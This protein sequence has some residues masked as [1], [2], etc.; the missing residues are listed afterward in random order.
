[1]KA[2]PYFILFLL[3]LPCIAAAQVSVSTSALQQLAGVTRHPAVNPQPNHPHEVAAKRKIP[4]AP[5]PPTTLAAP[6]AITPAALPAAKP[7]PAVAAPPP[8]VTLVFADGSAALPADAA[9]KINA[10][11]HVQ[12]SLRIDATAKANADDASAAMRLSLARALAVRDVLRGCGVPA[13]Q[14]LPRALGDVKNTNDNAATLG[15]A[16]EK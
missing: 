2:Y 4:A 16:T 10:F 13:E 6:P 1:M 11:C 8:P 12:L 3:F 7:Q 14:I 5:Q 9:T 15:V